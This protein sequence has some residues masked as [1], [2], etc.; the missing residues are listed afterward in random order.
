MA[1]QD[2]AWLTTRSPV[3]LAAAAFVNLATAIVF[4]LDRVWWAVAVFVAG[5]LMFAIAAFRFAKQHGGG[6]A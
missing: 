4:A 6:K 3:L 2:V 5:A 1:T